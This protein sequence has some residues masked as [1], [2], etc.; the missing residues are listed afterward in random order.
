MARTSTPTVPTTS[1]PE[2]LRSSTV[3]EFV[4]A[5]LDA[6]AM[7]VD[8]R[9]LDGAD[10][11]PFEQAQANI[12]RVAAESTRNFVDPARNGHGA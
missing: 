11:T 4:A 7:T 9:G 6:Q 10:V 12:L 1:L 2:F 5:A 8:N 3:A